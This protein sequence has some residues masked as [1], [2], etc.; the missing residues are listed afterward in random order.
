VAG[1]PGNVS[2]LALY[3]RNPINRIIS[4]VHR[5][6]ADLADIRSVDGGVPLRNDGSG[7]SEERSDA[8]EH[9]EGVERKFRDV[10]YRRYER[11]ECRMQTRGMLDG[12]LRVCAGFH[13]HSV[14]I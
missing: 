9:S 4:L 10:D 3:D 2:S 13:Y 6:L 14:F 12:L 8:C 11:G 7:K 5:N 1:K